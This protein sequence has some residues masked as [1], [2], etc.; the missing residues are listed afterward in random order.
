MKTPLLITTLL[1]ATLMAG[2]SYADDDCHDPVID[3]QPKHALQQ[4]LEAEG[5]QVQRIKVDDG[6]YEVKG[7]DQNG[8]KVKAEYYPASLR[9]REIEIK[10]NKDAAIPEGFYSGD[11]KGMHK[12]PNMKNMQKENNSMNS[13]NEGENL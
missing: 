11:R 1:T 3:W 4:Q 6:C 9:L 5:W 7:L 8:N 13:A 12:Q 10:F 2:A